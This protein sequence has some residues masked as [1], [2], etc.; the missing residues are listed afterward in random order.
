[1]ITFIDYAADA[2]DA[3]PRRFR[4][5]DTDV[6]LMPSMLLRFRAMPP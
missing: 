2:A 6:S 1:M 5:A 3:A 4:Y